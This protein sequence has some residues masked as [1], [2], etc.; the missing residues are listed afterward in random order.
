LQ[1]EASVIDT[2]LASAEK[3]LNEYRKKYQAMFNKSLNKSDTTEDCALE[4]SELQHVM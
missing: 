3:E 4:L 2:E 1:K